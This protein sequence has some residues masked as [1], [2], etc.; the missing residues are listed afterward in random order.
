MWKVLPKLSDGGDWP[1]VAVVDGQFLLLFALPPDNRTFVCEN[2]NVQ[3]SH[4]VDMMDYQS[5]WRNAMQRVSCVEDFDAFIVHAFQNLEFSVEEREWNKMGH[6]FANIK[7]DLVR[8][9][10][11]LNDQACDDWEKSTFNDSEFERRASVALSRESR[12][13]TKR[14]FMDQ[15]GVMQNCRHHT[16]ISPHLGGRIYFAI[17]NRSNVFVGKVCEHL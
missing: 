13:A 14:E 4:A 2:R 5:F 15:S 7:A 1:C 12:A 10:G 8:H 9:L 11:Y 16:K 6:Q 17:E 3:T